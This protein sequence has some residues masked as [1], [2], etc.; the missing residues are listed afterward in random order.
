[1][2]NRYQYVGNLRRESSGRFRLIRQERVVKKNKM[3]SNAKIMPHIIT[4]EVGL[5]KW[6]H[7]AYQILKPLMFSIRSIWGQIRP[8][9]GSIRPFL[10]ISGTKYHFNRIGV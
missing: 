7:L 2:D 10:Y 3:K 8:V 5:R 1:M 4:F 9:K 6:P